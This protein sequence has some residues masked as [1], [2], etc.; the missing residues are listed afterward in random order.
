MSFLALAAVLNIAGANLA[1][2]I[3]IPLYLDT[4]GTFLA[5]ILF[6]P[7]YG[8]VPGFLSGI[9]TGMTT[10]IYS[11]FYLPVQLLTGLTAGLFFYEKIISE[12]KIPDSAVCVCRYFTG[13]DCFLLHYG[14]FIWR[15]YLIRFHSRGTALSSSG[16]ESYCK[17]ILRTACYR[18]Y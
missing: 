10:D 18:F 17:R 12:R 11:L 3:R 4:L 2:L 14:I 5:A 6:G 15:N 8:M 13:N 7:F 16:T 1:L 9:L